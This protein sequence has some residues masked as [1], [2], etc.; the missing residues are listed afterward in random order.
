MG[1]KL[2]VTPDTA[3][4]SG[5]PLLSR[6]LMHSEVSI[7]CLGYSVLLEVRSEQCCHSGSILQMGK[8][9]PRFFISCPGTPGPNQSK[10]KRCSR[11]CCFQPL[12]QQDR[13]KPL[14]HDAIWLPLC[15]K[16]RYR[17]RGSC[18]LSPQLRASQPCTASVAEM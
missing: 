17:S 15:G 5:N 11:I 10:E 8:L 1:P 13:N 3:V 9:S 16:Y 14:T 4:L 12:D 2:P 7:A 6:A 18:L